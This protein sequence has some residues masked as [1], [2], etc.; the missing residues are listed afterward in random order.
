MVIADVAREAGVSAMTVSRVLNGHAAVAPATRKRVEEVVAALGYRAN[1]AASVLGGG[2]SRM[3]GVVAMET[4][5]FGPSRILFGVEAAARAAGHMVTF[6]SMPHP[7]ADA[8][9]ATTDQLRGAHVDGIVVVAP[10]RP[11][12]DAVAALATDVPMVAVGG[13]PVP[14]ARTVDIDQ[15]AG[16]RM[17]TEHLLS[18]GHETVHHVRGPANVIDGAARAMGWSAALRAAGAPKPATLTTD[19]SAEGGHAAGVTL[20]VDPEVTA[21]FAANDQTALGVIRGLVEG[22]RR[23][24]GD[25]SVVGFDDTPESGFYLPPLTTVRQDFGEVGRRAVRLLIARISGQG[26]EEHVT[27]QPELVVRASTAPPARRR[28]R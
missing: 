7:T 15:H 25:V 27:V 20:A 6:A 14:G 12:L 17:A 24:P 2:R 13:E 1:R 21:V 8:L 26:E 22:G 28:R 3:L 11:V 18:L 4:D 23:V 16:A 10:F 19:W 5:Q 9:E